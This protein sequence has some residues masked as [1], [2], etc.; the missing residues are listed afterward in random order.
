MNVKAIIPLAAGLCVGGFALKIGVD[1]LQK[2]KGTPSATVGVLAAK[3]DIPRGVKI[4]EEMLTALAYPAN[5]VPAGAL[6]QKDQLVGRVP[7]MEAPA[8]LPILEAMLLAPGDPGGVHVPPGLRAVAVKIDEGSGVDYHLE[9]GCRVDVV[10]TFTVSR[11]R[12]QET[13]ARTVIEDVEVAAVGAR[14]SSVAEPG[15]DKKDRQTRA[16]TLLVKPDQVPILHLAEQRGKI[17]LSLRGTEGGTGASAHAVSE[18]Q[19]FDPNGEDQEKQPGASTQPAK[20]AGGLA[21]LNGLFARPKPKT[22]PV[23][24][25]KAVKSAPPVLPVVDRSWLVS[26][27][28]GNKLELVRFKNRDSRER[29]EEQAGAAHSTAAPDPAPAAAQP[30]DGSKSPGEPAADPAKGTANPDASQSEKPQEPVE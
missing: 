15:A 2:A 11:E 24:D 14:L 3:V 5:L 1:M 21:W 22:E 17:K 20:S 25:V 23:A 18:K 10:G 28:R 7:R 4:T 19:L 12:G 27:W 29:V 26:V 13:M 30:A 8:G 6:K 16:V 9:P